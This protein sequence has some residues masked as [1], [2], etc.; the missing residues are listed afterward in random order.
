LEDVMGLAESLFLL[1]LLVPP[2]VV[3]VMFAIVLFGP[4]RRHA[5]TEAPESVSPKVA[6]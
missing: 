5:C 1:G 2:G 3:V 4:T 6:A